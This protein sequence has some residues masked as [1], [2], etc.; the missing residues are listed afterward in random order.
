MSDAST[1]SASI[2]HLAF[3]RRNRDRVGKIGE[4]A[5]HFFE[6]GRR[7]VD[8]RR[9][10]LIGDAEMLGVDVEQFDGY[11]L[12]N[13]RNALLQ[14]AFKPICLLSILLLVD[15][16]KKHAVA[17]VVCISNK[18][19][20]V[21]AGAF[22]RATE[23]IHAHAEIERSITTIRVEQAD[24]H[25]QRDERD[26]RRIHSLKFCKLMSIGERKSQFANLQTHC[27]F[28]D[29]ERRVGYELLDR[30][31]DLF[32][33]IRF[34]QLCLE[35]IGGAVDEVRRGKKVAKIAKFDIKTYK[36]NKNIA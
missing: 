15:K 13:E 35:H 31:D 10:F 25:L 6:L 4:I 17:L 27:A 23:L 9:I 12:K 2:A 14:D 19:I 36:C 3:D 34:C 20:V 26:V 16:R 29:V 22:E 30:L 7:H 8:Y 18:T 21:V 28:A 11:F 32:E 33:C 1:L 5:Y 24:A